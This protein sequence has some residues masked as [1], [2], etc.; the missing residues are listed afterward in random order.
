MSATV[1]HERQPRERAVGCT[2]CRKLTWNL[3]A[4]CDDHE[5][6]THGKDCYVCKGTGFCVG[7]GSPAGMV[8]CIADEAAS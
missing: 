6:K 1:E 3:S 7:W 5:A 8:P 2:V 4:R